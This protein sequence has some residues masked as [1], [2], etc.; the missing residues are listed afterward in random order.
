MKKGE[1]INI[2]F[3]ITKGDFEGKAKAKFGVSPGDNSVDYNEL[4]KTVNKDALLKAL[5]LDRL[6]SELKAEDINIITKEEYD[7]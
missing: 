6:D 2:Y 7:N 3:E 5:Q 1:E 4:V